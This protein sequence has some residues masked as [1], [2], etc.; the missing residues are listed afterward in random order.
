MPHTVNL[1][2][3][4]NDS[5]KTL[6]ILCGLPYAGKSF[7]AAKLQKDTD[8]VYVS[9]DTTF[10]AHGFDWDMNKVPNTEEWREI[11]DESYK[12]TQS[13]LEQGRN[14]LYDSTN[15][16]IASR[17]ALRSIADAV[18]ADSVVIYI[19]TSVETVWRRWEENQKSRAR[20]IV[21]K[22]LVQMTIGMFE[23]PTEAEN[24]VIIDN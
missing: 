3:K 8:V 13:A 14:V 11:F 10:H 17:D 22:E 16:T 15:Q 9:I 20:S 6:F 12:L 23:E 24:T 5:H 7:L 21:A 18:K 4:I 1:Q 19:K 2:E